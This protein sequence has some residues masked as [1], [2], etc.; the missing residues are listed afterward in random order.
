MGG[1]AAYDKFYFEITYL[2]DPSP[3]ITLPCLSISSTLDWWDSDMQKCQLKTCWC[4]YSCQCCYWWGTYKRQ[5]G[6]KAE[7]WSRYQGWIS[8]NL[9]LCWR[10]VQTWSIGVGQDFKTEI[11][12]IFW[13]LYLLEIWESLEIQ[14]GT[15]IEVRFYPGP[16]FTLFS[17]EKKSEIPI[18]VTFFEKWKVK[19]RSRTRS[20]N[21]N[22]IF[23][24]SRETRILLV[25]AVL[26]TSL[27]V[28]FSCPAWNKFSWLFLI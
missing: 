10:L 14:L 21:E 16:N 23:E 15:K 18:A 27:M 25:T 24:K 3:I 13:G 11:W 8:C 28:S 6:R 2:S 17:R 9:F 26:A 5:F 19:L 12:P 1:T 22:R 20:E 7:V 4:C